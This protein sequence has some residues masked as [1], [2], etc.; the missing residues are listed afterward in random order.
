MTSFKYTLL[1]LG[2]LIM[3]TSLSACTSHVKQAELEASGHFENGEFIN[4]DPFE[5]PGF[6]KTLSII[7]RF[8]VEKKVNTEPKHAI[9]VQP[10]SQQ[11]L[12][13]NLTKQ[14]AVYRLG[15]STILMALNGQLWL[16]DPVFSERASPVQWAGPKRF[17]PTP[18][19]V[20]ALPN[21]TGILI[22]HDH[23]DHLDK[24]TIKQIHPKVDGFY[25]P[26]GVGKHLIDWGVPANKVHEFDWWQEQ[27]VGDITLVNTPANHFSGRSLSDG[28]S[29]LWSSWVIKT[30][31][32]NLFFSGDSGYFSGFKEIGNKYG[33]FDLTMIENGAY[34]K[35]WPDVH[36]TPEQSMRAHKDLKGHILMPIHNGTFDLAFHEWTDPFERM[37]VLAAAQ[38]QVL[39]TPAMGQ[40][41][42]LSDTVPHRTWWRQSPPLQQN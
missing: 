14:T 5:K 8:I 32:H 20:A 11:A 22:S 19:D 34:D 29:T 24:N 40:R 27:Q 33:P 9:A 6:F 21:I 42:S 17:H 37:T 38:Q 18:I 30:S 31:Q 35:S 25:V 12:T 3:A 41:W 23:Y 1:I 26:L 36:M 15:H 13:N 2:A 4:S 16:T 10:I 39:A 7:K 28:N